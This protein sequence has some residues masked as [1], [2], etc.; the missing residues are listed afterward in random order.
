[1]DP[2]FFVFFFGNTFNLGFDEH[3][4]IPISLSSSLETLPILVL[5]ISLSSFSLFPGHCSGEIIVGR[6]QIGSR[7]PAWV[8]VEEGC[9]R[10]QMNGLVK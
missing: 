2:D 8:M 4:W 9:R 10:M 7:L 6:H 5:S 3:R 1:M